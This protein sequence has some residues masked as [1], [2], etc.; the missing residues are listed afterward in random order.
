MNK[1]QKIEFKFFDVTEELRRFIIEE[2]NA[3]RPILPQIVR[4]LKIASWQACDRCVEKSYEA[5]C[6]DCDF[7]RGDVFFEVLFSKVYRGKTFSFELDSDS[8]DTFDIQ[9]VDGERLI[10]W[11]STLRFAD[12]F[13]SVEMIPRTP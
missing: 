1:E 8:N 4:G 9:V 6:S 3:L 2:M 10:A 7:S 5:D 11:A 13:E 12:Y